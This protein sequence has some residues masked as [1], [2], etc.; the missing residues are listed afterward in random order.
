MVC[1]DCGRGLAREL[2]VPVRQP[3]AQEGVALQ[4]E[5]VH[6][7]AQRL[8][9]RLQAA[10][11]ILGHHVD[12]H[13]LLVVVQLQ[14]REVGL[15]KPRLSAFRRIVIAGRNTA[16][17]LFRRITSCSCSHSSARSSSFGHVLD[18]PPAG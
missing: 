2:L 8:G 10:L 7:Q 17:P 14:R 15:V 18:L 3:A 4:A 11:R 9:H 13:H 1:Q 12:L 16:R 6:G 5:V